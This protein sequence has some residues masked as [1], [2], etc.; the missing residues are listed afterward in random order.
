V[1]DRVVRTLISQW[2]AG[3]L[4]AGEIQ[5]N[6]DQKNDRGISR[7]AL[8]ETALAAGAM[9][10]AAPLLGAQ[11]RRA[12]QSSAGEGW[13]PPPFDLEEVSVT[14]LRDRMAR[15]ELTSRAI[16]ESYLAR[17]DALDRRGPSLHHIIELNPDALSIAD[18]LDAERKSGSVRGPLHGI[19]LLI[20]DNIDTHDRMSTSAGSLALAG[21][22][23]PRDSFVAEQLRRAGAVILGKTNLSEWANFRSSHSVS[24]WS[25]RGGQAKNPYALDR[26][27]SGSSSGSAGAVAANLCA[28]AVGSET[29][30]SIVSPASTCGIVGVKPTVGLVSRAGI[31]PISHTQDTAGPMARTVMDA[32]ILLTALAGA[33]PRDAATAAIPAGPRIDYTLSLRRDSLKGARLGVVRAKG[34]SYGSKID[35]LLDEAVRVLKAEGAIVV[36]PIELEGFGKYDNE[37]LTV[38]LYEFKADLN[39][40]LAALG[41]NAPMKTL[42]DLI[43]F[44]ES[45]RDSELQYFG[46]ELF[47]QAQEKGPLTSKEYLDALAKCRDLSR[48]NGIDATMKKHNLDALVAITGGPA[49]LIDL[50]N[51]DQFT[52]SD[53][54]PAAVAGYPHVTVP[55]GF[56][57]GL[58]IGLSFFGR[59]WT[60]ATLLNLA[61]GYEQATNARR[62]PRFRAH[63]V[64]L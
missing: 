41:P 6:D 47:L 13:V 46:Q 21:S 44:N 33:D 50:V 56:V 20:K 60:E 36:D 28:V 57:Q 4:S 12:A 31:I 14:Q 7:R 43:A 27:T 37:E 17:I 52:G 1:I 49:W 55:T 38:L 45:H 10:A 48:T 16:T 58:P 63:A 3:T 62:P 61:Y 35:P 64:E 2:S 9:A 59:A 53:S 11:E 26:N 18:A 42:A 40:Y 22:I 39:A 51:G 5:V 8:L 54:S 34:F 32:A 19:P 29:D 25:G 15:G 24:G 23:A 30:G